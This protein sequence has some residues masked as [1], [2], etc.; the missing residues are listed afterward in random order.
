MVACRSFI[1]RFTSI[2][3]RKRTKMGDS[4]APDDETLTRF[5]PAV[6]IGVEADSK[7]CGV[8]CVQ[9]WSGGDPQYA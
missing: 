3:G 7:V 9:E 4:N 5:V 2:K 1:H 8:L 6:E